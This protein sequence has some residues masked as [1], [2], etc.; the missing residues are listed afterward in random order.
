MNILIRCDS[1]NIIGTG[2]V[3]RCL[4]LSEYYPE[5]KYTFVCRNFDM[6]ITEKIIGSRH[7]LILLNYNLEPII[8][9]YK[10]W[11]GKE[12]IEEI[13]DL[14]SILTTNKYDEIIIDHYGIDYLIER[15]ITKYCNKLTVI[16]DIFDFVHWCDE[17]I[18]YNCDDEE[19]LKKINL[20]PNT[21]IK[22]GVKNIIINKKFLN[23][24][25]TIFREKIEKICI[26]LG[27]SDPQNYTLKILKLIYVNI[28]NNNIQTYI[29]IGKSNNNIDLIKEF[30]NIKNNYILLYDLNYDELI[31]L[32]MDIDLCIGSLSITAYER[33]YIN[34]PQICL[35]IA[36][37]QNIQ[38]L[39]EF[40]ITSTINFKIYFNT[41][42]HNNYRFQI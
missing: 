10:T 4:N 29:I 26:M 19:K 33:L 34:V 28:E 41:Y 16:S 3:M 21:I 8:N 32:Y 24:K 22:Y 36:K 18:N 37:N 9:N 15:E 39:K 42:I 38:E 40:N 12:Y 2:H 20:N 11:I 17:Y 14:T 6:N 13:N 5:N 1:S 23:I 27:G 25:K 31:K 35:K 7:K 30:I